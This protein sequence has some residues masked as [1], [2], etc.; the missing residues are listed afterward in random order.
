ME[1]TGDK[2]QQEKK[3]EARGSKPKPEQT[4]RPTVAE[5]VTEPVVA[6]AVVEVPMPAEP[7][8]QLIYTGPNIGRGRLRQYTVFRAGVPAYLEP[9]LEEQPAIRRLL[10]PIAELAATQKN[11]EVKGTIEHKAYQTLKGVID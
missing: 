4:R 10:V 8:Q 1:T 5:P 9:L 6:A 7:E 2:E 11:I 3:D